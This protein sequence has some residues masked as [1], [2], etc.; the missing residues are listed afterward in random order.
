MRNLVEVIDQMLEKIPPK[1]DF[2]EVEEEIELRGSLE[3]FKNTAYY[4]APEVMS[5][6]WIL[7]AKRL[8]YCL[9]DELQTYGWKRE[10]QE[11]WMGEK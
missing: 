7:V 10:V 11:I 4:T 8:S 9:G 5:D 2:G 6:L 3:A 1:H